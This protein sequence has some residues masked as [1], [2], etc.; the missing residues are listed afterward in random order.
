MGVALHQ[1]RGLRLFYTL[2]KS[3]GH[4]WPADCFVILCRNRL[5]SALIR[6]STSGA[7]RFGLDHQFYLKISW[8]RVE[9]NL[10]DVATFS[11]SALRL[12]FS[13][14][15]LMAKRGHWGRL[16][17]NLDSEW[18]LIDKISNL[19]AE[20]QANMNQFSTSCGSLWKQREVNTVIKIA[21]VAA[22]RMF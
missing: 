18:L 21:M 14:A 11:G 3:Y 5:K 1:R 10:N 6:T 15:L 17:T 16:N 22:M 20:I 4:R 12:M 19:L 9:L 7:N 8:I 2:Q 13:R